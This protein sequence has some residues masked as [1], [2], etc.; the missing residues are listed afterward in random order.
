MTQNTKLGDML[1]ELS[2][3]QLSEGRKTEIVRLL[4]ELGDR[5]NQ[6]KS[7]L[8]LAG[9]DPILQKPTIRKVFWLDSPLQQYSIEQHTLM[10]TNDSSNT[11]I[12]FD[13]FYG[14]SDV[15]FVDPTDATKIRIK[16]NHYNWLING[17]STWARSEERR[18]GKECRL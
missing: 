14:K 9:R 3:P 4:N 10:S 1:L 16:T 7:W 18:V 5:E 6:Y 13:T 12:T 11:Y 17:I 8:Q 15:F 2:D